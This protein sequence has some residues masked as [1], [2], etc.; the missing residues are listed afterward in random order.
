MCYKGTVKQYSSDL[1]F[2]NWSEVVFLTS[3]ANSNE[4]M[5]S[6]WFIKWVV[7]YVNSSIPEMR[8][9]RFAKA[10]RSSLIMK[11]PFEIATH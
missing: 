9:I 2:P 7:A 6:E 11:A 5:L 1:A 8:R 4:K 10:L 3:L